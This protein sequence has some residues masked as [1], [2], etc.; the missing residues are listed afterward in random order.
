[1]ARSSP[2]RRPKAAPILNTGMK[3]PEGTGSVD[4]T[5]DMQNCRRET[6]TELRLARYGGDTYQ[7]RRNAG[8]YANDTVH[9]NLDLDSF[10]LSKIKPF[11][12]KYC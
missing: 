1:M 6:E 10:I 11:R 3:M 8:L 7:R 12:E 5:T 2:T 4:A 9:N